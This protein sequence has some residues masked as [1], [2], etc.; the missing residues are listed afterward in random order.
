M[1]LERILLKTSRWLSAHASFSL[2]TLMVLLGLLTGLWKAR[3][4]ILGSSSSLSRSAAGQVQCA[5]ATA[6]FMP[7]T[8]MTQL[9]ALLTEEDAHLLYGP[10]EFG[11]YQLRFASDIDPVPAI[12][13]MAQ[14]PMVK[15]VTAIEGCL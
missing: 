7:G 11:R 12:A 14:N 9:T 4:A 10:D 13:R 5:Q 3:D 2:L 1:K 8:T 6:A 15:N